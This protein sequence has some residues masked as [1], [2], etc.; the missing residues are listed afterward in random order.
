[1][2]MRPCEHLEILRMG[3]IKRRRKPPRLWAKRILGIFRVRLHAS[4]G[5]YRRTS[6]RCFPI[7]LIQRYIVGLHKNALTQI[8]VRIE[9]RY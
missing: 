1:M 7:C 5:D 4:L 6:F 8:V 3:Y 2:S 9:D